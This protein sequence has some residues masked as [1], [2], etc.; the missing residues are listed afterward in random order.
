MMEAC[1]KRVDTAREAAYL[2]N[3]NPKNTRLYERSGFK[4]R[5]S[6]SPPGAPPLLAMWRDAVTS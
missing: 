2:E 6:I 5:K 3:S 4:T 1:L